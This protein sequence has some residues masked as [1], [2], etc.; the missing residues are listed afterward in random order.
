MMSPT[1]GFITKLTGILNTSQYTC[2]T[3]YV[4]VA[5]KYGYVVLQ[6]GTTAI[7]TLIENLMFEDH[8][9]GHGVK[10]QANHANNATFWDN[11]WMQDCN[12]TKSSLIR[13]CQCSLQ[14]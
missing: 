3:T 5:S 4:D 14:K 11:T 9:T 1:L 7:V 13:L 8:A 2:A 12:E 10:I 6:R